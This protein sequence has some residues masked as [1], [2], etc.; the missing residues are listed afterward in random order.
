M[1]AKMEHFPDYFDY[2]YMQLV[3]ESVE[4]LVMAEI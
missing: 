1:A 4:Y 2:C 3:G